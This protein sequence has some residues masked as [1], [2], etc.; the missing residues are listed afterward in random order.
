M[1]TDNQPFKIESETTA[2]SVEPLAVGSSD[3]LGFL[4]IN[5]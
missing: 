2:P 5:A 4:I 3:L 1:K